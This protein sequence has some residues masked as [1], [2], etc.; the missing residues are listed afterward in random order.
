MAF[1][2]RTGIDIN[3]VDDDVMASLFSE[4]LGAVI[5]IRKEEQQNVLTTLY[6]FG[7]GEQQIRIIGTLNHNMQISINHR[8]NVIFTEDILTLH[9]DWSETTYY[10]QSLRDNPECAQQEYDQILDRDNSGLFVKTTFNIE[11]DQHTVFI[12]TNTKPPIAILR[13]QGVNGQVEMAAA[14]DRAGFNCIDVHMND[15][16]NSHVSLD[17]FHGLA[18]CG[19]FSFGDVLGAGGGWAKSILFNSK[20]RDTFQSFFERQDTFALGVCNGC[21]MLAQLRNFIPGAEFWPD[22]VRN[23]SEQ[24]EARLIMVEVMESPSILL[25]GMAGSQ[26]PVV[27]AHGEGKVDYGERADM[28]NKTGVV[29]RYI[30]NSGCVSETYPVNPNGSPE[31]QTG[32][33]STDGRFTIMMPHPERLFLK[34]QFSWFPSDWQQEESPWMQLFINARRWIN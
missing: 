12:N 19:G 23:T 5:Q 7:L 4:E 20:V 32:F 29:L 18:A 14:F 15:I 11:K 13:E 34:K 26:L 22:F 21:Q 17:D 33:T 16:I 31:G 10:M 2:G 24:F 9:R 3:L 1:A 28:M 30:D 6:N 27:V 8:D 25:D